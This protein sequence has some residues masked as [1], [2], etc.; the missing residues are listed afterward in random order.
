MNE[1]RVGFKVEENL[2][3]EKFTLNNINKVYN[4]KNLLELQSLVPIYNKLSNI[5]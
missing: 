2:M 5:P 1:F 4:N 3:Q